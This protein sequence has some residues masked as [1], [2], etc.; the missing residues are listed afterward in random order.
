MRPDGRLLPVTDWRDFD[1]VLERC[2]T[3]GLE[4]DSAFRDA[5]TEALGLLADS[6]AAAS[7][8]ARE[9]LVICGWQAVESVFLRLT[10]VSVERIAP[11]GSRMR[12][13]DR[14]GRVAGP[15]GSLLRGERLALN[16]LCR[17][18]GIAT[19]TRRFVEEAA[20]TGVEILDT[21]KTTPGMRALE[22]YAVRCGGGVNHRFDLASMAMFKDNHVSAAGGPEAL[23]EPVRRARL[24]G[25]PVEIEVDSL[26]Q[27]DAVLRLGPD[28]ILL[29]NLPP[30][31]V[32][33][34]VRRAAGRCYLEASG[35]ITVENVGLYARTGVNGVSIGALTHSAPAA[36]FA[37]DWEAP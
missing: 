8:V 20:G 3:D 33:E 4:E 25:V 28:R 9:D 10:G 23:S 35:G 24:A 12:A 22:R 26:D 37:M 5:A 21:R 32:A 14:A 19:L 27:L 18:S 31:A 1:S 2:V 29:D 36:D 11:E 34:A 15:L 7:V 13:G 17:L 16:L 30:A 6:H